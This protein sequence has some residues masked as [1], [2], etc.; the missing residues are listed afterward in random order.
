M[1]SPPWEFD[2]ASHAG[3]EHLDPQ[4]VAGYDRKAATDPSDDVRLMR[5]AGVDERSVVVDLGAHGSLLQEH[6]AFCQA[7]EEHYVRV[8]RR[9][10]KGA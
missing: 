8:Q 6:Q 4:Y 2:E 3:V 5:A 9:V 10:T 7:R 1:T